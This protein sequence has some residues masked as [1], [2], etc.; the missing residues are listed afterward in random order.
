MPML[1]CTFIIILLSRS[2]LLYDD[3]NYTVS[4]CVS[5]LDGENNKYCFFNFIFFDLIMSLCLG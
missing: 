4:C 3:E 2:V 1:C 5:Y